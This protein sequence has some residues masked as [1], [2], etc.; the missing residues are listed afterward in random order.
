MS[1]KLAVKQTIGSNEHIIQSL[2]SFVVIANEMEERAV[3]AES[4]ARNNEEITAKSYIPV[5][6]LIVFSWKSPVESVS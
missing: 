6:G 1:A 4:G 3:P 5:S 2:A